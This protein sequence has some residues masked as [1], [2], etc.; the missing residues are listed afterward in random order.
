VLP[1]A[2]LMDDARALARRLAAG[3]TR[4][5]ANSKRM[6]NNSLMKIM[7]EQLDLEADV[8]GEM[9]RSTDFLEGIS[10]FVEKRDPDFK[11][12]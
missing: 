11:G 6:L 8:Q 3:P 1:D 9:A 7:D 5:Y 10:A 4:S 2:E 12:Q